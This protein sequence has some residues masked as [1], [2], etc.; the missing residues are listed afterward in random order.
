MEE[1]T[2]SCSSEDA[3]TPLWK[4]DVEPGKYLLGG[5]RAR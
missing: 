4:L 1:E 3:K 5:G 2:A